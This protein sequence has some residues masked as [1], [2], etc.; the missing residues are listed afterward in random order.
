MKD[1]PD[2]LKPALA[3]LLLAIAD[4]KLLLGHRNSDWTGLAPILEEDIAFSS[5][6]QDEIAHAQTLY[7]LAGTLVGEEADHLAFG[8]DAAA[9]RSAA[10]VEVPD[11]FDW[12]FAIARRLLVDHFDRLRLERLSRSSW[13]PLAALGAR[14]VAEEQVHVEHVN[15]WTCRLGGG[16]EESRRRLQAA[17]DRIAPEATDLFEPVAG[18]PKLVAAGVYPEPDGASMFERWT[19]S[20][21]AV[22]TAAGLTVALPE[23]DRDTAG[24]RRG[25]HTPHLRELLD[26]MCEVYRIEPSAAW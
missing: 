17:L 4:D 1:V 7:E 3:D 24:G 6:A 10:I 18:E 9:F 11:E 2:D 15:D 25:H 23:P 8:R 22:T 26:E 20:V 21:G 5:L 19:T 14:L 13:A 12:A 16:N